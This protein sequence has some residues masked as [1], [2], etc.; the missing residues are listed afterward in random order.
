LDNS[1]VIKTASEYDAVVFW[2]HGLGA[3]GHDFEDVVPH[4]HLDDR[5][6]IKFV[7]PHAPTMPVTI[8]NGM[9]MRAWFD[10]AN[11]ELGR[12]SDIE[13][14]RLSAKNL[15]TWIQ[16]EL[17]NG[18]DSKRIIL[19]GFSQGGV[20]ALEVGLRFEKALGGVIALSTYSPTAE[21]LS[22]EKSISN[23]KIPIFW[24]H[25]SADP[26]VSIELG[27]FTAKIIEKEGFKVDFREYPMLPHSVSM[28]EI[29]EIGAFIN[30]ILL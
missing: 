26:V 29:K 24:G 4:L 6:K 27:R 3:D 19:A 9:S 1:V 25:G 28:P 7:F 22:T 30:Q 5:L 2:L 23:Q 12:S 17:L 14:I 21:L 8:N 16:Q 18:I 13:G 15:A 10:I 20:I 11:S